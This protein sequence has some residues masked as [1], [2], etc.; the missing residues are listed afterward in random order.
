MSNNQSFNQNLAG[1]SR[2]NNL[3]QPGY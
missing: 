2:G 3:E 1:S